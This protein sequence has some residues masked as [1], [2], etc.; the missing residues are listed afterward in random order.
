MATLFTDSHGLFA[1]EAISL[2]TLEAQTG[3][4]IKSKMG[5]LASGA[6]HVTCAMSTHPFSV[7]VVTF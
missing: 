3:H 1:V 5:C 2:Y 6:Y 4:H 7:I